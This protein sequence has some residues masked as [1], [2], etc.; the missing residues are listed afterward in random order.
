MPFTPALA[1][2][3]AGVK[4]C[5]IVGAELALYESMPLFL[6]LP[7]TTVISKYLRNDRMKENM[8]ER[9]PKE[10]LFK[11]GRSRHG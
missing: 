8:V 10:R 6:Q 5:K 1:T 2:A 11:T 7:E 9:H 4:D 3:K